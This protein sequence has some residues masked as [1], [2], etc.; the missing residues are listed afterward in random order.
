MNDETKKSPQLF[1]ALSLAWE[2]GYIIAI[3]IVVLG[4]GGAL[5]DKKYATSPLFLLTG[6][7]LSILISSIGIYRKAKTI[8]ADIDAAS[9][10]PKVKKEPPK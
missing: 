2:L 5:L 1:N 6:I 7:L 4:F 10:V 9:K 8:L 3:P